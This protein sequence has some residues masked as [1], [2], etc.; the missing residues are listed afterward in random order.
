MT[1]E[2]DDSERVVE[3]PPEL[4]TAFEMHPGAGAAFAKLS[5]SHQREHINYIN[6]GKKPETRERRALRTVMNLRA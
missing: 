6:E 5:F 4:K 2:R 3:I 1:V